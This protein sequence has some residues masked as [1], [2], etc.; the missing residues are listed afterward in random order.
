MKTTLI[1]VRHG[2]STA[3]QTDIFAGQSNYALSPLGE[4][5][6]DRVAERLRSVPIT[7]IYS[8][9]LR[10]A[11]QTAEPTVRSHGLPLLT[12]PALREIYGG[13]WEGML[14]E[15]IRS[16]F[17]DDFTCWA[18][19]FSDSRPTG[20]ESVRE[21]FERAVRATNDLVRAN[22][23]GC[24]ALF[25]HGGMLRVL[26]CHWMGLPLSDCNGDG[27]TANASVSI[28]EYDEQLR[29]T[30]LTYASA[31]HLAGIRTN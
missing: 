30:V 27:W 28:V 24:I 31:D 9:G 22:P 16:Q 20:G 23:G 1:F 29:P 14:H 15:K 26:R 3:N 18:T 11:N 12:V 6:A 10:R 4:E 21:L 5:Q 17:P 2:Q 25:S 7:A 13:R 8:S 19:R